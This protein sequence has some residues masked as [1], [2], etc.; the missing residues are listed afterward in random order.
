MKKWLKGSGPISLKFLRSFYID[1][2]RVMR[3]HMP[4]DKAVVF[5]DGFDLKSWKDF[6][7]EEEFKMPFECTSILNGYIS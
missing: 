3:K 6:K 5:H 1:A 4:E 2:Y 7:R